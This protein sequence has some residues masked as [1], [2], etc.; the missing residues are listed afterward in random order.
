MK[1]KV[2]RKA[3]IVASMVAAMCLQ[4][5]TLAVAGSPKKAVFLLWEICGIIFLSSS[6]S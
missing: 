1:I 4:G 2:L 3:L 5:N 6:I